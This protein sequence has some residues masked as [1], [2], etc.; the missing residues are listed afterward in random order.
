M[1]KLERDVEKAEEKVERLEE[2]ISKLESRLA[3][4]EGAADMELLQKYL[5]MKAKL[6]RAMNLWERLAL[7]LEETNL[8]S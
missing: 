1:R 3:T 5:E 6:D 7:E 2:K 8:S 4:P